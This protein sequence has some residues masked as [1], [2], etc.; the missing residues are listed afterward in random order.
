MADAKVNATTIIFDNNDYK[1]KTTGQTILFDGYLKIYKDIEKDEPKEVPTLNKGEVHT[2]KEIVKEQH[3]TEPPSRYTE[4]KLIKEM[5]DKGIGR[6]STY[7]TVVDTIKERDYVKLVDKKFVPTPMGIETTDKLQEF[8]SGIINVKYTADMETDLDEI[9]EEKEDN[10]KVLREFY[11]SFEPLVKKAFG[12]MEKKPAESTGETC[13]ECGSDLVKRKGKFG[14]FVACSNY[15]TC[16]Y[17]KQEEKEVKEVKE[18]CKCSK[19]K[20]GMIIERLTRRG[21]PF[22]GCSRFPKCKAAYWDMPTGETCPVC[23]EALVEH[24]REIKCS[25]CDY[26][27][28]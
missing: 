28:E 1:F 6:P 17:I 15:P 2:A 3:F 8:F 14:E 9:A 7:A 10:I 18:I 19:C 25:S 20:E 24:D 23:G 22:Y 5:E 11:D 27:K 13:P 26:S 16:K 12:E 21:K 4:G